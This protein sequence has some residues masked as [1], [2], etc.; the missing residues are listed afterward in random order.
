MLVY[1]ASMNKP[2]GHV[3]RVAAVD[4][5]MT[6]QQLADAVGLNLRTVNRHMTGRS[7]VTVDQLLRYSEVLGA[8]FVVE[9]AAG[10][11]PAVGFE[12]T[13]YRFRDGGEAA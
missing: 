8:Q 4:A 13:T 10:G 12:P 5:G 3:L 9:P 2:L 11:A 6:Q 1:G 7:P